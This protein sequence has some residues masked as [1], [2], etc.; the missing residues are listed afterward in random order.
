MSVCETCDKLR[1]REGRTHLI[2]KPCDICNG[3]R[4]DFGGSACRH[5]ASDSG[6]RKA[7]LSATNTT[8]HLCPHEDAGTCPCCNRTPLD[9]PIY[10]RMTTDPTLVTCEFVRERSQGIRLRA[11]E[12]VRYGLPPKSQLASEDVP[13]LLDELTRLLR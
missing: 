6:S 13:W 1:K 3:T 7:S 10:D 9:L 4:S 5:C 8:T 12:A 11:K 2:G